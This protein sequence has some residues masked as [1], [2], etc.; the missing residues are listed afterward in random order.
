VGALAGVV[1]LF[2]LKIDVI[3]DMNYLMVCS[4]FK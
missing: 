2:P 4:F 1:G 3:F